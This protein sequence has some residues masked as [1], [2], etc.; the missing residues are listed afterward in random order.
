MRLPL[1]PPAD[2]TAAQR[3]LY[4]DMRR[5]IETNFKG[6]KA[7][8]EDGALIGPWNRGCASPSSAADLGPGQGAVRLAH[9]AQAGARGGDPGH[10]R[11]LPFGL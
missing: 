10:R 3:P 7:I 8:A 9:S 5:G 4:E 2:L 6:F 1:H 11:A